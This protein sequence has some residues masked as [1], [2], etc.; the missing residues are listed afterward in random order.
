MEKCISTTEFL[1]FFFRSETLVNSRKVFYLLNNS[2][3]WRVLWALALDINGGIE[4]EVDDFIEKCT[5]RI[6]WMKLVQRLTLCNADGQKK[7]SEICEA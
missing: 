5:W 7:K 3:F 2:C 4:V 6:I 1:I